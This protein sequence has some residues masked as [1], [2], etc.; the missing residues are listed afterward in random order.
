MSSFFD[1][2]SNNLGNEFGSELRQSPGRSLTGD[3]IGHLLA[4]ATNLRRAGVGGLLDLVWSS[5][6][7]GNGEQ[8]EE[9]VIGRLHGHI[10]FDQGL[11][12]ADQRSKLVRGEVETV[13]VCEAV[14]SL[15]LVHAELDLSESVV[16]IV[17]EISQ[18]DF[19]DSAFEGV[20]CV[21]KTCSPVDE[22]LAN[23]EI[24][25]VSIPPAEERFPYSRDPLKVEGA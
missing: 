20:V 9:V 12:L 19:E 13:E 16:F 6:G 24:Q 10:G 7:K 3:D 11:P 14:L 8:A 17:L 25:S 22:R 4:N 18:G 23:P 5:L 21:L 1:L 2:T 15:D